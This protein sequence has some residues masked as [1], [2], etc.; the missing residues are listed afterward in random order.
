MELL[1]ADT[2]LLTPMISRLAAAAAALLFLAACGGGHAPGG[3][4]G[5]GHSNA[6]P[7]QPPRLLHPLPPGF[8]AP[9]NS[10]LPAVPSVLQVDPV[11]MLNPHALHAG[12]LP[13]R[14]ILDVSQ[15]M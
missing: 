11:T 5:G 6:R 2:V 1:G 12:P 13:R 7:A 9:G 14:Q 15:E 8:A 4:A 3:H 10:R